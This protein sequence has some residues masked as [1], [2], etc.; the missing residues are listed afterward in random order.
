MGMFVWV[1]LIIRVVEVVGVLNGISMV[2]NLNYKLIK[3][4]YTSNQICA[5]ILK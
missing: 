2:I 4:G 3:L 1:V 5:L